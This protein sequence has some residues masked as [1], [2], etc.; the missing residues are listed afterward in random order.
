MPDLAWPEAKIAALQDE[1][2][3]SFTFTIVD[4]RPWLVAI[5]DP[6]AVLW[7]EMG[8]LYRSHWYLGGD[9]DV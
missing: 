7:L 2:S 4:I 8:K 9:D 3:V 5:G 1:Y 6:L